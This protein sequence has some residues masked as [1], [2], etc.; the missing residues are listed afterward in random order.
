MLIGNTQIKYWSAPF[1]WN[2]V[3]LYRY[4]PMS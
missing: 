3:N 2:T 4:V 1:L